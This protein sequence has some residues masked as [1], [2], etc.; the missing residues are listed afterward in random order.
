MIIKLVRHG[1]SVQNIG[2]FNPEISGNF[3]IPLTE[4][5]RKQ[6][7]NVC[8]IINS[9]FIKTSLVYCS[10]HRRTRET[11]DEIIKKAGISRNDIRIYEDPRLREMDFGYK[12]VVAQQQQRE[13]H[14][15][16]YYRFE[17][18]ESPADCYDR[19]SAFLENLHR[20]HSRKGRDNVLIISHG[21]AIRCFIM[22]FLHLTVEQFDSMKNPNNC[23]VI[24]IGKIGTIQNPEFSS[25]K[26]AVSGIKLYDK[27][28]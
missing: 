11:L 15:W 1:E 21:L 25:R 8:G 12:N 23:D 9:D 14:G 3:D 19:V 18:G 2:D 7:E 24:T 6:A 16:F 5:G 20:Q 26:W 28:F 4:A 13:K 17:G 22:R 10:P 27:N